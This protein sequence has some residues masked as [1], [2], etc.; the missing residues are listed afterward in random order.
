MASPVQRYQQEMHENIGFFATWLPGDLLELGDIGTSRMAYSVK[1]HHLGSWGSPFRRARS[2][3]HR[4]YNTHQK[5][6][7]S[8]P[9][10]ARSH[11]PNH[12]VL[13]LALKW[14]SVLRD[15]SFF[16]PQMFATG[17]WKTV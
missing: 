13:Q 4:T 16:T 17:A 1:A 9:S 3:H 14:N 5:V 8:F 2:G 10:T 11:Y 7:L 15:L 6:G 12:L